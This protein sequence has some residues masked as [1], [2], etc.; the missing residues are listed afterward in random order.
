MPRNDAMKRIVIYLIVVFALS[1]VFYWQV[2]VN[3]GLSNPKAE[4]W[5]LPLM[6]SP[7]IAALVTTFILQRN[8]HGLG[9]GRPKFSYLGIGYLLPIVYAGVVYALVWITGLGGVDT[10]QVSDNFGL[11]L[12]NTLTLGIVL[13]ALSAVGEEIGWRGL[14]IPQLARVQSFQRTALISG[15]IWGLWHVPL[16]I[17][18]GYSSG[19]PTWYAVACF[20]VLVIGMSFAFAWLRLASG[21]IWPSVIMHAVHNAFIQS[22]LDKITVDTGNTEYFTTEFGLGLAIVGVIIGWFFWQRGKSLALQG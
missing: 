6:W 14:L 2:I 5:V 21:S 1:S 3:G 18:G 9:W 13:S 10:T 17:G 22:V 11:F 7:G 20:M 19:A 4:L 8:F 16:I 12:A 15:V